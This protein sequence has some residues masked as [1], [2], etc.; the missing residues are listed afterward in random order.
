MLRK[1]L[2]PDLDVSVFDFRQAPIEILL[3]WIRFR[4]G[5]QAIEIGGV[6]L[7]LPMVLERVQVGRRCRLCLL[8][9]WSR[10]WSGH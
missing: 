1:Q 9:L 7:V 4:V 3:L 10:R 8:S 2:C 6:C 5:K